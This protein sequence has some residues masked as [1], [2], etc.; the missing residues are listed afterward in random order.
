MEFKMP[1]KYLI[2]TIQKLMTWK[3]TGLLWV[4][5]FIIWVPHSLTTIIVIHSHYKTEY[6]QQKKLVKSMGWNSCQISE[7]CL[8]D[9]IQGHG[10]FCEPHGDTVFQGMSFLICDFFINPIYDLGYEW[11]L[12]LLQDQHTANRWC[13]WMLSKL[14]TFACADS[15]AYWNG[16]E[17][18]Q[19]VPLGLCR[20]AKDYLSCP[21][22]YQFF[23]DMK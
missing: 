11:W 13:L 15:L 2:N 5:C 10:Q 1:S 16:L 22:A 9:N 20:M 17:V 7:G 6:L 3:Y 18:S 19:V 23:I 21:G 4:S 8:G 12:Q 14:N